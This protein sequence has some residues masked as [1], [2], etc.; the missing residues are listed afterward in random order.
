[1][2]QLLASRFLSSMELHLIP[3]SGDL[4]FH[5]KINLIEFIFETGLFLP[6]EKLEEC[7]GTY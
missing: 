3:I 5:V 4:F 7:K 6:R 2:L 1:M